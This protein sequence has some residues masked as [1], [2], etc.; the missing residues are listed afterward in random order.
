[1]TIVGKG[2]TIVGKFC[3]FERKRKKGKK[4][5]RSKRGKVRIIEG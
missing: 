5:K 1:M 2:V 3:L 4:E